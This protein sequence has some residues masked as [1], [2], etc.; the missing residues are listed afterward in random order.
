MV[1]FASPDLEK[2]MKKDKHKEEKHKAGGWMCGKS[3]VCGTAETLFSRI[4]FLFLLRNLLH[5]ASKVRLASLLCMGYLPWVRGMQ[6]AKTLETVK[7]AG[8]SRYLSQLKTLRANK[9]PKMAP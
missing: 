5:L 8:A 4:M 2:S 6:W 7:E 1:T 9:V 3:R